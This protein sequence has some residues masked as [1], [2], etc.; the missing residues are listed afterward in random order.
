V[1]HGA[2]PAALETIENFAHQYGL[3]VSESQLRR[4]LVVLSGMAEAMQTAF[5]TQLALYEA[6]GGIRYRGRTGE[7][8]LP[9]ELQ[10][11]VLAVLGLD[12]RPAARPHFRHRNVAG[13][14]GAFTPP[15]LAQLYNFP[16]GVDGS[17][18]TIAIIELGGGYSTNDLNTYFGRLDIKAPQVSAVS[19]GSGQNQPGGA[20]DGEVML[21]IEVAGAVAPGARIVVY[22][23]ENTDQGFHDAIAAAAHDAVRQP[24]VLSISWG[25][26]E[27]SWTEQARNAMNAALQDAAAMGVTVTVAAGDDGATDREPDNQLHVDF[28]ASSPFVLA[29]GGTKLT[30]SAG[31][32]STEE[33]WNELASGNGAT[34]GGVS[35]VFGIPEYQ[36][37]VGVPQ[38]PQSGFAGR[39]VPDVAGDADPT[40]GYVVLVDGQDGVIG[41]TS[42]VAPLWAGL[43]ALINQQ[44]GKPLGFV[45]P[46]LY[47]APS[48]AFQDI[49]NGGNGGY[50][51]GQ[52]WDPCTGLGTPNGT[53]LMNA[54]IG[55]AAAQTAS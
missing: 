19:V 28:P 53:A 20:A 27:D 23:A 8:S 16:T 55:L 32:I 37:S 49:V 52:N 11:L 3:S 5:G 40:T 26:S 48:S 34:G 54:L 10:P 4:R 14:D 13:S 2:V 12:N 22:F 36:Q 7:I 31:S 47:Q 9:A 1:I 21:D 33:V 35:R 24:S 6:P 46:A 30:A 25:L 38:H 43:V 50:I 18:Q 51:A 29:C 41:G 44:L 17:G 39:G 15:Q 42:A 45:N